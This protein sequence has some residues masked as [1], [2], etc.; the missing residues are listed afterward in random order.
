M[1]IVARKEKRGA[2]IRLFLLKKQS[3]GGFQFLAVFLAKTK[4]QKEDMVLL[5]K[6]PGLLSKR[7][8]LQKK[9]RKVQ[10]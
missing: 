10:R 4:E 5:E 3:V 9:E 2:Q 8:K 7:K 1:E 6:F